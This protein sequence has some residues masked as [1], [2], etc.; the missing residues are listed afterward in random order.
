MRR[1]IDARL[2]A[3]TRRQQ[4]RDTAA[5]RPAAEFDVEGFAILWAEITAEL[6]P[7]QEAEWTH[8]ME[9]AMRCAGLRQSPP[10]LSDL[11]DAQLDVLEA[12]ARRVEGQS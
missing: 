4:Q 2:D 12:I 11:T 7:A 3:L 10:E 5:A 6:T 9:V 8:A 1:S